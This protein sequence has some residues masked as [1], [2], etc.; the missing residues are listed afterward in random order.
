MKLICMSDMAS[1]TC[2]QH[3]RSTW[4]VNRNVEISRA[5]H[6]SPDVERVAH[7]A[8]AHAL[9]VFDGGRNADADAVQ[10]TGGAPA[11]KPAAE[12]EARGMQTVPAGRFVSWQC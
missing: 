7:N 8:A 12:S 6:T 11:G 9:R 3:R 1:E 4:A 10:T 5:K 2:T